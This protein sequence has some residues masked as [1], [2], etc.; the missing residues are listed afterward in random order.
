MGIVS[1]VALDFNLVHEALF[2]TV[3]TP[4]VGYLMRLLNVFSEQN[5][6]YCFPDFENNHHLFCIEHTSFR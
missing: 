3:S 4:L 5:S 6:Y 1:T 2:Y